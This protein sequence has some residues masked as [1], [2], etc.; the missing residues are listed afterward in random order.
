MKDSFI[1][2]LNITYERFVFFSIKQQKE[3]SVDSFYGRLTEQAKNCS[4]VDEETIL[5]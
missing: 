1:K 3:E 4:L 5:I 2:A